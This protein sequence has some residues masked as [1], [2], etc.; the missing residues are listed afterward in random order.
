VRPDG[1][2]NGES[3]FDMKASVVEYFVTDASAK[4]AE[5]HVIQLSKTYFSQ[6]DCFWWYYWIR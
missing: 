5:E 2:H 6:P 3:L 4:V 1:I